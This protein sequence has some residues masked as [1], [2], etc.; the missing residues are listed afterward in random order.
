MKITLN[1]KSLVIKLHKE[2]KYLD[3]TNNHSTMTISIIQPKEQ[4]LKL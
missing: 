1:K 3:I 2:D 4:Q